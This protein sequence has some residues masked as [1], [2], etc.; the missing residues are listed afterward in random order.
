M[1][2]PIS[3]QQVQAMAPDASVCKAGS[4]LATLGKWVSLGINQQTLWGE[5][6]G[7]GK[8]P[9]QAQVEL[10]SYLSRCSCPSRKFPCKH[11]LGL[12]FLWADQA[13]PLTS[14]SIAPLWAQ[15]W[16]KERQERAAKKQEKIEKKVQAIAQDPD[17]QLQLVAKREKVRWKKIADGAQELQ[18]WLIDQF[19]HGFANFSPAHCSEWRTMAARMVDAQAPGLSRMLMNALELLQAGHGKQQRAIEQL[20]LIQVL[21]T[22]TLRQE[23]LFPLLRA[24]VRTA[25]GWP[26]DKE[27]ILS[28]V[29]KHGVMIKDSWLVLGEIISPTTDTRLM[30]RRVWLYGKNS[31]QYALL[32]DF[33]FQSKGFELR[34]QNQRNYQ[35][36]LHY[37]PSQVPLRAFVVERHLESDTQDCWPKI[38]FQKNVDHV[39]TWFAMIPW[40]TCIPILLPDVKIIPNAGKWNLQ[41]ELGLFNLEIHESDAWTLLAFSGGAPLDV[42]AEWNGYELTPLSAQIAIS[43][44][45]AKA[46]KRQERWLQT[47]C[48][49]V[50]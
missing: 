5:C 50:V 19:Q 10:S 35:A 39:S 44:S 11:V 14:E 26:M 23:E 27:E 42:F 1:S 37:Y 49:M 41:T 30:E 13:A 17:S 32:L 31:G 34:W 33:A 38:S 29:Q 20:G 12:L 6:K 9:Y 28:G 16:I 4:A 8:K 24:D 18:R 15:E 7:S 48:M 25:L 3:R 2:L 22:A 36:T 47:H 21:L 40:L 43:V 46:G 45:E